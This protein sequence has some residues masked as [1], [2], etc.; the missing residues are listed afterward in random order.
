[1]RYLRIGFLTQA[2]PRVTT[3]LLVWGKHRLTIIFVISAPTG[4]RLPRA[5]GIF[6]P[7][8]YNLVDYVN[9]EMTLAIAFVKAIAASVFYGPFAN[10]LFL[11]GARA[12]R[13]GLKVRQCPARS[14]A[15]P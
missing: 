6:T 13:Y 4:Q 1:M 14:P 15:L 7:Q 3:E 10:G 12:L 8:W 5:D 9:D 2:K 11:A